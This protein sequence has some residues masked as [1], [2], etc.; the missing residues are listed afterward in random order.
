MDSAY[1]INCLETNQ[2][3][4]LE[5]SLV[6]L[7]RMCMSGSSTDLKSVF[8]CTGFLTSES[9]KIL[10]ISEVIHLLVGVKIKREQ[11]ELPQKICRSCLK[12]LYTS[13]SFLN[14][15]KKYEAAFGTFLKLKNAE[16]VQVNPDVLY[17]D[18]NGEEDDQDTITT[19]ENE[20]LVEEADEDHN[21]EGVDEP[22]EM[23]IQDVS[24]LMK[25][26]E[27]QVEHL[28][29]EDVQE[30]IEVSTKEEPAKKQ[31]KLQKV[32]QKKIADKKKVPSNLKN[33][34]PKAKKNVFNCSQC[35]KSYSFVQSLNR[36]FTAEHGDD[37]DKK[38]CP[39]CPQQFHRAD[40]LK[41]HIRTHTNERPYACEDCEKS[42]KQSS[43]LKDHMACHTKEAMYQCK[44]CNFAFTTRMG[45][46]Y[47]TKKAHLG[48]GMVKK[49]NKRKA[50]KTITR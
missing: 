23:A 39:H 14:L 2:V 28:R 13:Y 9:G 42:F 7:C 25:S 20:E 18:Q 8:S 11:E 43:E 33:R 15:A 35:D 34:S 21:E 24:D 17:D 6:N 40:G 32:I 44:E 19:D 10:D 30:T 27:F 12:Q 46:H 26:D 48:Q 37:S 41:R 5:N 1:I 4:L 22:M 36:H 3:D 45:L 49:T 16:A 31:N 47:H 38:Q 50:K 29:E